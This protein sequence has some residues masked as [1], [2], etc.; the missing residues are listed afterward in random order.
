[1][2]SRLKL[3][4]FVFLAVGAILLSFGVSTSISRFN[5]RRAALTANGRV[6]RLDARS[7]RRRGGVS[8]YPIVQFLTRNEQEVTFTGDIGS[9]PPAFHVD[10]EVAVLYDPDDPRRAYIHTFMQFWGAS[11]IL[12]VL[13]SVFTGFPTVILLVQARHLRRAQWLKQFGRRI[14]TRFECVER[15]TNVRFNGDSPYRIISRWTDPATNVECV[16][17][18]FYLW[19]DPT[20]LINSRPDRSIDVLIDPNNAK[21]YWLDTDFLGDLAD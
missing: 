18:S 21:R 1:M 16:F 3:F 20:P 8:Y 7:G 10:E 19:H 9:R 4:H 12:F 15:V 5:F 13:G 17:H 6:I 2:A 11:F 14:S